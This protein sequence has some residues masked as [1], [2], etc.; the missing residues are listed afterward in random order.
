MTADTAGRVATSIVAA[1]IAWAL[2]TGRLNRTKWPVEDEPED[3]IVEENEFAQQHSGGRLPG[4]P[5][6]RRNTD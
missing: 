5:I 3:E 1:A 2:L 6:P 4:K